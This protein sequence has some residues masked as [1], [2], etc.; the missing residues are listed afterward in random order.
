MSGLFAITALI[1]L[2]AGAAT[3]IT[4]P[5]PTLS[6]ADLAL[7]ERLTWGVNESTVAEFSALGRDR[8]LARQLQPGTDRL[9]AAVQ[10]QIAAMPIST[11]PPA[12]FAPFYSKCKIARH[13]NSLMQ[14]RR[15]RSGKP[16]GRR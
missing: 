4:E 12:E 2:G 1:A 15:R 13:D 8:W 5:K 10:A 7:I 14:S 16:I 9:P 3:G 6:A 11:R